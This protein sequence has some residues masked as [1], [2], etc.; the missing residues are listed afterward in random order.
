MLN[1]LSKN[2]QDFLG[3]VGKLKRSLYELVQAS[4]NWHIMLTEALKNMGFKQSLADPCVL[5]WV[6][7]AELYILRVVQVDDLMVASNDKEPVQD[8]K[9]TLATKLSV[10]DLGKLTYYMG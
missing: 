6:T 8:F 3:A 1:A 9:V 7:E 2:C 10:E 4:R 5:L